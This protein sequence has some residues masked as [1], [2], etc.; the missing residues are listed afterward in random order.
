MSNLSL[1][2]ALQKMGRL[3]TSQFEV[4]YGR[5]D[6]LIPARKVEV[7]SARPALKLRANVLQANRAA[8]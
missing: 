3:A 2:D 8:R 5:P 6:T 1:T 4:V 7:T